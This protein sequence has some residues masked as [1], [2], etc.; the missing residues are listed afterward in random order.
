MHSVR[1][2]DIWYNIEKNTQYEKFDLSGW[3]DD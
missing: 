1:F 2:D 3:V